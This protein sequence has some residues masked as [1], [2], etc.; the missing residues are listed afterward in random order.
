MFL[1]ADVYC[2]QNST[3]ISFMGLP[4]IKIPHVLDVEGSHEQTA[5]FI[6]IMGRPIIQNSLVLRC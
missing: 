3:F 6:S 1:D 5:T 2:D 4:I